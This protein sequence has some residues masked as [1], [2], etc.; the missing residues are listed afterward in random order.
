MDVSKGIDFEKTNDIAIFVGYFSKTVSG[1]YEIYEG[2][3]SNW[4]YHFLIRF[5]PCRVVRH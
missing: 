1:Y 5:C 4:V 3:I 2:I